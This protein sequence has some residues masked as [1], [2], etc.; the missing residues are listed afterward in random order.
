MKA[1]FVFATA[2]AAV[3]VVLCALLFPMGAMGQK[4]GSDGSSSS[5]SS[6]DG[7]SAQTSNIAALVGACIG[8]VLLIILNRYLEHKYP[9]HE[10]AFR[11]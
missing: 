7:V 10:G 1:Y 9:N 3:F 5:S 6:S 8:V 11:W 4:D 2:N